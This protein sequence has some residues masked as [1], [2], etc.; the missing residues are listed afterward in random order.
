LKTDRRDF[1]RLLASSIALLSGGP[2]SA[3]AEEGPL[4]IH[5]ATRNTPLCA[6]GA[7]LPR[8]GG[9]PAPFKR[10]P[11]LDR[12]TLPAFSSKPALEL[13]ESVAASSGLER[14]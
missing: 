1:F 4:A 6:I 12:L 7:R 10:Y 9:R 3:S 14:F 11:G 8:L 5:H 13:P 2:S